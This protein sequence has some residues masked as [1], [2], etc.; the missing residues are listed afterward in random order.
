M[1]IVWK[2]VVIT[3]VFFTLSTTAGVAAAE[4][5]RIAFV[6]GQTTDPFYISVYHGIKRATDALGIDLIYAGSSEWSVPK[7][8]SALNTV[9][10]QKP[11]VILIAPTDTEKLIA[12]L[13]NA[14]KQGIKIITL[15]NYIDDGKYQDGDG[16]GDFPYTHIASDNVYGGRLA[17]KALAEAIGKRGTV[18]VVK[19]S[20]AS[21]TEMREYGFKTEMK[22]Y[23]NIKIL[24]TLICSENPELAAKQLKQVYA[25]H[26]D[27]RGVFGADLFSAS[28]A[29]AGVKELGKTGKIKVLAFD[30]TERI[31]K[32]IQSG[33]IDSAIAQHPAVIG[34]YGAISA[35]GIINGEG[36]PLNVA[37]GFTVI[38]AANIDDP[39]VRK[40]IYSTK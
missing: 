5:I 37:T 22:R 34:Y 32:D 23:R 39:K 7:Q 11:A 4:N 6:S 30:A 15:D 1:Q 17:A 12:P 36:A 29:A 2:F 27:L 24:K 8:I 21:T 10:E 38:N 26:P 33:Q 28:G 14:H 9:I 19:G 35:Y 25:E 3:L 31:A 13:K 18:Y 16:D 20:P 40:Y